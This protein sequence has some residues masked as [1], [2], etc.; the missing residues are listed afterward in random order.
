MCICVFRNVTYTPNAPQPPLPPL[1]SAPSRVAVVAASLRSPGCAI[2]FILVF[3]RVCFYSLGQ[4]AAKL[5]EK[6]NRNKIAHRR[7]P[8]PC[9]SWVYSLVSFF[10]EVILQFAARNHPKVPQKTNQPAPW[11]CSLFFASHIFGVDKKGGASLEGGY[12][13]ARALSSLVVLNKVYKKYA[14]AGQPLFVL[15]WQLLQL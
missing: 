15:D 8:L 2:L 14:V 5:L 4:T 7:I 3:L 10:L 13:L 1:P 11:V 9:P 6:S 12:P